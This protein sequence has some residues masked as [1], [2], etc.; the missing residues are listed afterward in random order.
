M[1]LSILLK[2]D[3]LHGNG[4]Q[5]VDSGMLHLTLALTL[6]RDAFLLYIGWNVRI[7]F[8]WEREHFPGSPAIRVFSPTTYDLANWPTRWILGGFDQKL[9]YVGGKAGVEA[10]IVLAQIMAETGCLLPAFPGD[11]LIWQLLDAG[12]V[13]VIVKWWWLSES[14]ASWLQQRQHLLGISFLWCG[15]GNCCWRLSLEPVS[16]P[17]P[18]CPLLLTYNRTQWRRLDPADPWS[19]HMP[20]NCFM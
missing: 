17:S 4:I 9:S 14:A 18:S 7:H 10:S 19:Q 20:L 8:P 1:S 5:L 2:S 11:F 6:G 13:R 3:A 16:S 12:R 15:L